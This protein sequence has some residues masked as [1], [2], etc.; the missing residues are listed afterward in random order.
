MKNIRLVLLVF[1]LIGFIKINAQ[2]TPVFK[3]EQSTI[4]YGKVV[5][6]SDG[7]RIFKFTNIGDAPLIINEVTSSCGCTV[8]EKPLRPIMPGEKGEIKVHYD[9]KRLGAFQKNIRIVSN[10]KPSI[11]E[12]HIKGLVVKK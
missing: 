2:N 6:G 9:T 1:A 8:P 3:F 12:V 11:V 10:A 7:N 4:D 5:Q